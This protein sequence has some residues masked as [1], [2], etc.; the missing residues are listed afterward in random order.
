MASKYVTISNIQHLVAKIKAGFAAIGH[1]HAA[2]DI[3]SGTLATDRLPTMPIAKG[4]T[5]ATDASTA[6]ANLGITPANIG[7][8]T[9]NHTHA[10]MKGSTATTAGSAGLAPAPAA[11]ASNRYLRSDG[12]WQVPPD[13]N[14]TYG[15]ATQSAN[16]LMSA[17]DKKKL[18]TVQLASWPIG[19]IMMTTTNTN[20]TTSLGGTWKQLEATGFTGYLWQRTA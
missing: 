9:A 17:A 1:K 2:G 7:A 13:T 4:G 5:G 6:R 3:T 19:A 8:A 12:T 20:P 11:G 15:T 14:T 16:G 10:T 18:D